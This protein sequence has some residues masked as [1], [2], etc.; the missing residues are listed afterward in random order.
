MTQMG[1]EIFPK[2]RVF[3]EG[4]IT[5]AGNIAKNPIKLHGGVKVVLLKIWKEPSVVIGNQERRRV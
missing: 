2:T 3:A 1:V 4:S 5:R